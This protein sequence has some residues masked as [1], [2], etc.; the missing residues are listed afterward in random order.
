MRFHHVLLTTAL[1]AFSGT[2]LAQH[3][4]HGGEGVEFLHG[5]NLTEAQETQI[6]G[7]EKAAW[8]QAR[9]TMEQLRNLHQ[10][11]MTTLLGAGTV[12]EADLAPIK[13]QEEALRHQ[14]DEQHLTTMLQIRQVLTPTQLADA[15]SKFQQ[16]VALRAQEHQV[17]GAHEE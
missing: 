13:S 17:M 3:P 5:L 14:L 11:E 7:I 4:W 15:S 2:A 12:T 10:Q 1:I 8:T 9:A 6:K 16:I